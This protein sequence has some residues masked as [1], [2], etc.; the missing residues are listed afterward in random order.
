MLA[1]YCGIL[2]AMP[3]KVKAINNLHIKASSRD[4][5]DLKFMGKWIILFDLQLLFDI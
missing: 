2:E 4:V 5:P 1:H 3:L